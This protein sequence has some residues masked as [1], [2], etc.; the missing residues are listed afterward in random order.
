MS[1]SKN[2]H[3]KVTGSLVGVDGNA[4]AILGYFRSQAM[5]EGVCYEAIMEIIEQA[6][7]SDYN[8]LI[9]TINSHLK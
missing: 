3:I 1:N 7:S 6:T 4:F 2:S 5:K 9:A 8:Y